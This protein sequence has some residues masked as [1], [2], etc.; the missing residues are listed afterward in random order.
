MTTADL[1]KKGA[2]L[3]EKIH[4]IVQA[5]EKEN[6]EANDDEVGLMTAWQSEA[7]SLNRRA[8]MTEDAE[9]AVAETR[10]SAGRIADPIA[11]RIEPGESERDRRESF[12]DWLLQVNAACDRSSPP[13]AVQQAH[14]YLENQYRSEFRSWVDPKR[15]KEIRAM[16]AASGTTGG[17]LLPVAFYQ[18]LM[19]VGAPM[20]IVRPRAT[21]IPMTTQEMKVNS[22]DQTTAPTAG[23]PPYFGG[24]VLTWSGEAAT[25]DSTDAAFR[26]TTLTMCELTGYTAVSRT[27]IQYSPTSLEA[28]LYTQFGGAVAFAEDYVFLRGSG[29]GKPLGIFDPSV[30]CRVITADRGSATAISFTNATAVWVRVLGESQSRGVWVVTKRAETAVLTM[31]GV[32]NAVFH[33]TG[34]YTANTDTVNAGP[35]GVMLFMRPVL[36]STKLPDID[37]DGDFGFYDF[38]QYL[39]GDGGPPEIASSD[40]YLFRTNQRAFR[41]V[42]RVAGAPWLNNVITLEDAT[43]TLSPFVSL[44]VH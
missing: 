39:I 30:A 42:H 28:L 25:I 12:G 9:A 29:V 40:D 33:P 13:Q 2:E 34:V 3:R 31:A 15:P 17:F 1:R 4:A 8:K 32:T 41:I 21:V 16:A 7:E 23:N 6:R 38:S 11:G 27:L 14:E 22:L 37:I 35:S 36:V 44:G 26:Q 24:V 20:A 5:A 10:Q 43:T 18:K 19:Q